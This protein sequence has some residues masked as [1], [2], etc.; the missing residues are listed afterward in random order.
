MYL[1]DFVEALYEVLDGIKA[2]EGSVEKDSS[3]EVP[4]KPWRT[5]Q[6]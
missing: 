5:R 4:L 2:L 3:L 6:P 1:Y